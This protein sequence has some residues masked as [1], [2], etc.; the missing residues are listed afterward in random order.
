M[1]RMFASVLIAPDCCMI[2]AA[3]HIE[4]AEHAAQQHRKQLSGDGSV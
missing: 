2:A 3:Q 4:R 1:L